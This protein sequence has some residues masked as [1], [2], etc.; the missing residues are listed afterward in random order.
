MQPPCSPMPKPTSTP[1]IKRS[2][3][4]TALAIRADAW[5]V[6]WHKPGAG[7]VWSSKPSPPVSRCW[8]ARGGMQSAMV[9]PFSH[10]NTVRITVPR[11]THKRR[12][13]PQNVA[14]QVRCSL[15]TRVRTL[16]IIS[17]QDIR[18]APSRAVTSRHGTR[19]LGYVRRALRLDPRSRGGSMPLANPLHSMSVTLC[20]DGRPAGRQ[21]VGLGER[22]PCLFLLNPPTPEAMTEK[23]M[24]KA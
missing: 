10:G 24:E 18:W 9:P 21:L 14:A 12:I 11:R 15:H 2:P 4:R 22:L 8:T 17:K 19:S 3:R 23:S 5:P 1:S 13:E 16:K 7:T 20:R 6:Q